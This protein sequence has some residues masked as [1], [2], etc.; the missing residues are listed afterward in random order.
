MLSKNKI[1]TRD[2]LGIRQKVVDKSCLF[3]TEPESANHLLFECVVGKEMWNVLS[4]CLEV[5]LR[6]DFESVAGK[7]ICHKKFCL[8][9]MFT[10]IALWSLRKLRNEFVFWH[11]L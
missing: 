10:S 8:V 4:E 1:L 5:D 2:N 3:C 9:N 6:N 7:W 11:A